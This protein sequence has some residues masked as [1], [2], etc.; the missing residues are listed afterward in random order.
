MQYRSFN[1][2]DWKGSALGFGCMRL[3]TM[4]SAPVSA[5]IVEDEAIR[6]IR[7]AIDNGVNY[8]DTAYVYHAG[9]SEIV[10]GKALKDG[11]RD[12]V[13]VATKAPMWLIRKA[14]EYDQFLDEQ[15]KKLGVERIDLYLFHGL[16]KSS[17]NT[18]KSQELLGRAEAALQAG[19]IG[20]IAFSFHD[21]YE[22]FEE[23][24]TG[25]DKWSMCQIQY[26][27]MDTENQAGTRGLKLAASRGLGVV[28]M[29]PLLG[30]KLANPPQEIRKLLAD[31]GY[32]GS[33]ADLAL[34]WLWD[35]PEVSVVLSGMS[36]M[37]QVVG[38]IQS[39]NRSAIG[40]LT[41][42]ETGLIEKIKRFYME[43][44]AIPCTGCGYCLPCPYSVDIPRNLKLY[45]DGVMYGSFAESERVYNLFLQ[46]E[47]R[48][49][50][51]MQC[52]ACEEKCP[53]KI[54]ISEWMLKVQEK[55]A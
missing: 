29:E 39:A 44:T 22:V 9:K 45:N 3:P 28:V 54:P 13:K 21:R 7:H 23:I 4:D 30:G 16:D 48:A 5:N 49:A 41:G 55:F 1:K 12:K 47:E 31:S 52:K 26:N 2:L 51:C 17:W 38:N 8:V 25:Y 27:F 32:S 10:L 42:M 33:A 46:P 37:D 6:M 18:L 36:A 24:V 11:Y 34:Q 40:S 15:L 14:E 19:K 50:N 43:K 20:H 35:Q 53:Q